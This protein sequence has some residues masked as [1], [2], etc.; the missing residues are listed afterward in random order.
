MLVHYG[1]S[2]FVSDEA[3]SDAIRV[4]R[5]H[6]NASPAHSQVYLAATP[7]DGE[8]TSGFVDRDEVMCLNSCRRCATDTPSGSTRR[9][10]AAAF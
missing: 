5:L 4:C 9:A 2:P 8:G 6:G 7:G 3:I 10:P 1:A